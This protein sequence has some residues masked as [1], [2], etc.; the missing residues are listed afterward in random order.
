MQR[1]E[2]L[3]HTEKHTMQRIETT[4]HTLETT[5]EVIRRKRHYY[6]VRFKAN[7]NSIESLLE[8]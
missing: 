4:K 3:K 6:K 7:Y 2:T 8:L 5:Q 1:I